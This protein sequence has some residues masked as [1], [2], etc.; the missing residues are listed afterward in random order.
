MLSCCWV[1]FPAASGFDPRWYFFETV[2]CRFLG[3]GHRSGSPSWTASLVL[4][5]L[6]CS[7]LSVLAASRAIPVILRPGGKG[8]IPLRSF[9]IKLPRLLHLVC[10]GRDAKGSIPLGL[11]VSSFP[12]SPWHLGPRRYQG[13]Q[14]WPFDFF[15]SSVM[16][17]LLLQRHQGFD[18]LVG[19]GCP[20]SQ[21]SHPWSTGGLR[22]GVLVRSVTLSGMARE[23]A[24]GGVV[25]GG[26]GSVGV[27]LD[28]RLEFGV[29]VFWFCFRLF[30]LFSSFLLCFMSLHWAP[31]KP[32]K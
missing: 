32:V 5:R 21:A 11:R 8:S 26:Y 30:S 9:G 13:S 2:R 28:W 23:L 19:S 10:C 27:F 6:G 16:L 24:F 12:D 18:S 25:R 15:F 7:K 17:D 1:Q 22:D 31:K 20:I 4:I 14:V 29:L 3:R